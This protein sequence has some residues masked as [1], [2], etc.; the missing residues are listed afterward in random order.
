MKKEDLIGGAL[1]LV[2]IG[3]FATLMA[4]CIVSDREKVRVHQKYVMEH[5]EEFKFYKDVDNVMKIEREANLYKDAYNKLS[6]E[7][8]ELRETLKGYLDKDIE[9]LNKTRTKYFGTDV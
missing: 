8:G 6:S 1:T 9:E 5:P 2:S 4:K 7:V 3:G